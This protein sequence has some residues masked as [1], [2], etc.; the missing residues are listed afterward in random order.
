MQLLLISVCNYKLDILPNYTLSPSVPCTFSALTLVAGHQEEHSAWK[1]LSDGVLVWLSIWNEVQTVRIWSSWCHCHLK[2]LLSLA[3]FKSRLALPFWY[4]LPRV[5]L[6][7]T[8]LNGCSNSTELLTTTIPY[9]AESFTV[10]AGCA[11]GLAAEPNGCLSPLHKTCIRAMDSV[12]WENHP[13]MLH[14]I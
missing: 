6:E 9:L 4:Q 12:T 11:A 3:S 13:H 1:K 5:F 2:T 14:V 7:N 8:P 10:L